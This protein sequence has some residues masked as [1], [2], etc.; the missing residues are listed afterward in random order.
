[1]LFQDAD[2]I[3]TIRTLGDRGLER[4]R[5]GMRD[6][7]VEKTEES[8]CGPKSSSLELLIISVL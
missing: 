8:S 7:V 3:H 4:E 6:E 5:E 1:M 2:F